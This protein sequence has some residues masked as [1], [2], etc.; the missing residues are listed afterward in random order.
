MV[1]EQQ[2]SKGKWK[3][4]GPSVT[5]FW[6]A[7]PRDALCSRGVLPGTVHLRRVDRFTERLFTR[8]QPFRAFAWL[9]WLVLWVIA[10]WECSHGNKH[11]VGLQSEAF[12]GY[13]WSWGYV[14]DHSYVANDAVYYDPRDDLLWGL[15]SLRDKRVHPGITKID[16]GGV[17]VQMT[18]VTWARLNFAAGGPVKEA[19]ESDVR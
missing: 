5:R 18:E 8:R 9:I 11:G 13:F 7:E 17:L 10:W 2:E 19:E 14:A 3:V 4:E 16:C 1:T 6:N 15:R 12:F